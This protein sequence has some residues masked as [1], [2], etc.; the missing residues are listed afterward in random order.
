M[1]SL[2][3]DGRNAPYPSEDSKIC[4]LAFLFFGSSMY[5]MQGLI[6]RDEF[7]LLPLI[8]IATD[9]CLEYD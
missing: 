4:S 6:S 2:L 7:S 1:F 8:S 5:H 9:S 3:L